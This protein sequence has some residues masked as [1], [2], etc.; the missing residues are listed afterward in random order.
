[1]NK[2]DNKEVLLKEIDLIQS[3]I[4]RMANNSFLV[5]GWLI[6]IIAVSFA[7]FPEDINICAPCIIS[8]LITVVFWYLDAFFLKTERLYRWKYNW[9]ITNRLNC[10][11]YF[12]D[13]NPHNS[14]TWIENDRSPECEPNIV[15][16]MFSKTIC[17]LYISILVIII[18][19]Y[20]FLK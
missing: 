6:S 17:P 14:N 18:G 19:L 7:L 9:V 1:M 3:C 11:L 15:K 12:Y 2:L 4:T 16:V 8:A 10:D 20:I 13:L 5:K